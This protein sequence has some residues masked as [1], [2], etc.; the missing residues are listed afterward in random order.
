MGKWDYNCCF[1]AAVVV[2]A[3]SSLVPLEQSQSIILMK[4][5]LLPFWLAVVFAFILSLSDAGTQLLIDVYPIQDNASQT[6][7]QF[8]VVT[9]DRRNPAAATRTIRS[10]V[11]GNYY[12]REDTWKME[13]GSYKTNNPNSI[14]FEFTR[15]ESS[16]NQSLLERRYMECQ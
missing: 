15:I 4:K 3:L 10:W 9:F 5:K 6:L 7:W 11:T 12:D 8:R 13:N 16:D 1:L 14:F 2:S